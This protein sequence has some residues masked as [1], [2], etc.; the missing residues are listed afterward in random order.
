MSKTQTFTR[1]IANNAPPNIVQVIVMSLMGFIVAAFI[2]VAIVV[3][4]DLIFFDLRD[5]L[6]TITTASGLIG[7]M[8]MAYTELK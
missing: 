5:H 2:G 3:F 1:K 7:G 4:S 8:I 6:A